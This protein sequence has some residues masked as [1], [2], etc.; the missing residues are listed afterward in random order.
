MKRTIFAVILIFT[1]CISA[2]PLWANGNGA[3]SLI[4]MPEILSSQE[5][6]EVYNRLESIKGTYGVDAAFVITDKISSENAQAEADYLYDYGGYGAGDNN[7]GILYLVCES[8]H[9]YA[10]STCGRGIDIFNDDALEYIDDA[11]LPYL[12]ENNYYQAAMI[13]ADKCEELLKMDAEG[14][15]YHKKINILYVIGGIILIPLAAA[16]ILMSQ[17]LS[18][19]NTAVMQSGAE[20]Y[21]K[22]GSMNMASSR[23]I[24]LYSTVTKHEKE[25][26]NSKTHTSS[27]GTTHGGRSGNF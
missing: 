19:M 3:P 13:Y 6:N 23:D 2:F 16:F 17:K 12:K 5:Y 27:S 4:D 18:K 26:S 20:E 21:M 11:I 24:F 22:P 7:D 15:T 10:F 14:K 8:T 25:D 1:L 9:E